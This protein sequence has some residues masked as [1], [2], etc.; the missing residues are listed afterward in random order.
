M[1]RAVAALDPAPDRVLV[2]GNR[3]PPLGVPARAVIGGDASEPAISAASVLAKVSRDA[4]MEALAAAY[5]GYGFE[6]HKG[7]GTRAHLEALG[8]LGPCPLHRRSFAPVRAAAAQTR[9]ALD[10]DTLEPGNP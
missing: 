9:L 8:R 6:A 3:C 2:D 4:R 10:E 5:P 7:Y 1:A